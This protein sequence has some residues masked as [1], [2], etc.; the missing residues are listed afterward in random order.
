MSY[1]ENPRPVSSKRHWSHWSILDIA[2]GA[3]CYRLASVKA[4]IAQVQ[5]GF[6]AFLSE[7]DTAAQASAFWIASSLL[8]LFPDTSATIRISVGPVLAHSA[9]WRIPLDLQVS[10]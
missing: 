10:G 9:S 3:T 5:T 8:Q 4:S 7:S 2:S 1:S 6:I